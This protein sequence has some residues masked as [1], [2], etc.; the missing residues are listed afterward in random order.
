MR[1]LVVVSQSAR[2]LF[3]LTSV[4]LGN[5]ASAETTTSFTK[6]ANNGEAVTKS[7]PLGT[8][9]H[10]WACTRDE[11]SGLMWEVKATDG[12]LRDRRSTYTPFDSNPKTNGGWQGYRDSRSGKCLRSAIDGG[13]CNTEA[14]VISVNRTK[15]C[16]FDDWRLPTVSELIDVAAETT[17]DEPDTTQML[18][19]NT[20][21]GW[22]WTGVARVGVTAFSRVVLLPTRGRPSFYDGSYMVMVVR[23]AH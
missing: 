6:I 12:G 16:G 23:D 5:H 3:L 2:A 4:I 13:S 7:T 21:D 22:Y 10:E 20:D 14:Y 1:R 19:P 11:A 18:L 15:L 8:A 9:A 17:H